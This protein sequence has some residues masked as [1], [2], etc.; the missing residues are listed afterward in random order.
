MYR[1]SKKGLWLWLITFVGVI[2]PR[3]LRADWRQEWEAELRYHEMLLADWDHLN[4][5]RKL[6]L[7]WHSLGAFVDA[8]WLQPKRLEDEMFQD[9]KYGWRM[10]L[11]HKGFTLV[12]VL[13]LALGIGANT[14]QFSLVDT[15]LLRMLPVR[16]PDRLV[17]FEWD[18]GRPF[19]TDGMRGTFIGGAPGRRNA[20]IFNYKLIQTMHE[21]WAQKTSESPLSHLFAFA[22]LYEITAVVNNQAE[23][24]RGQAVTGGYYS[25]L[26]VQP[27]LGRA[28]IDTDDNAASPPVVMISHKYWQERFASNPNVIGQQLKLNNIAFSIVGVTPAGFAGTLQVNEHPDVTI[29]LNFEPMLLG[30]N[31][32]MVRKDNRSIWWI[33]LMGRL[34]PGATFEQARDSLNGAF[35]AAALEMMPPPRK[36]NEPAKIEQKDYPNLIAQTGGRGLLEIRKLYSRTI[37][38]LFTV[39]VMVLLIA[40]ANVANLLL[41]R[42]ALRGPE[43][44]VRL[45][46]GAGRWRLIRQLLTESVLLAAIGGAAGI[47]VA[48]WGKSALA[49]LATRNTDFLPVGVEPNLSWRV[50]AF[51][52]GVSLLTGILF[53]LAPAWRATKPDL[54]GALKQSRRS[55]SSVSKLS[56][57]LIVVQVALSL[58][59]LTGAGLYIRTLTNLQK[60]NLGFNQENLLTFSVDPKQGGYKD[61]RLTQFYQQLAA[62]FDALPGIQSATFA[63]IPLIAQTMWNTEILLPGETEKAAGEHVANRQSIRENYF[64]TMQI[65]LLMGRNFTAQDTLQAPKVAIVN[66]TF[67]R[68][69]FPNTDVLGKRVIDTDGKHEVEIVGIVADHKYNSQREDIEPL[70]YTPWQQLTDPFG[71]MSFALRTAGEPTAFTASVRQTVKDLDATLPVTQVS[72]QKARSNETLSQERLYARLLSFFGLLALVLAAIGLSGVLAY[73][74]AQRTNEIGIRMALGAQAADVLRMVIWQGLKLVVVGLAVG[75]TVAYALKRLMSS[76]YY[77]SRTWQRHMVEQLYGV[78]TVD[79]LLFGSIA[80]L[81]LLVAL[82]ACWLPARRAAQVDPLDALRHE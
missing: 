40:C 49:A 44:S 29:P 28:I 13:S 2:V 46:V 30:Q 38:G 57:A 72:S 67:A 12:A 15:V 20:S 53:G 5:R 56:K 50:L 35:Q 39:V 25:G 68:K 6:D 58:L 43:I 4:W 71:G 73:S 48:Y 33:H 14:A 10:L 42:A 11:K 80:G 63:S 17:L 75:A 60:V 22:P 54:A 69:F 81:L 62:R 21:A 9:L 51:T 59:L 52:V 79:P 16:E 36:D 82:L 7:M 3:H 47:L 24:I 70:L 27:M 31:S 1:R 55:S 41:A 8:L 66:Q 26:G 77:G 23:I 76:E 61:E 45:A 78:R 32:A 74:V 34:K 37:Y 64:T 18:A 19:R 65:P